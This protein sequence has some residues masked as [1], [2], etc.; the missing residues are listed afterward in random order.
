MFEGSGKNLLFPFSLT[1]DVCYNLY[2]FG[3]KV[4]L[5]LQVDFSSD[6]IEAHGTNIPQVYI[7]LAYYV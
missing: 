3:I 5:N 7:H 6:P 2:I 4:E 1:E